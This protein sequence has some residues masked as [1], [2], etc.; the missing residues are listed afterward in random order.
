MHKGECLRRGR[1]RRDGAPFGVIPLSSLL[2]AWTLVASP[3]V[4]QEN[5]RVGPWDSKTEHAHRVGEDEAPPKTG[6]T[7]EDFRLLPSRASLRFRGVVVPARV[8]GVEASRKVVLQSGRLT[9]TKTYA[10]LHDSSTGALIWRAPFQEGATMR[11]V[12]QFGSTGLFWIREADNTPEGD[13]PPGHFDLLHRLN[14]E[15]GTWQEPFRLGHP[16][17]GVQ[18]VLSPGAGLLAVGWPEDGDVPGRSG[19]KGAFRVVCF[20]VDRPQPIWQR[21]FSFV[22]KREEENSRDSAMSES[23]SRHSGFPALSWMGRTLLVCTGPRQPIRAVNGDTGTVLRCVDRVWEFVSDFAGPSVLAYF[24]ARF[25]A[26]DLLNAGLDDPRIQPFR[27]RFEERFRGSMVGGPVAVPLRFRRGDDSHGVFVPYILE[28]R[29]GAVGAHPRSFIV[30]FNDRLEAISVLQLPHVLFGRKPVL[31]DGGVVWYGEDSSFTR[32]APG[33][34]SNEL[35]TGIGY[36]DVSKS[37]LQWVRTAPSP[38]FDAWLVSPVHTRAPAFGHRL[39]IV[40]TAGARILDQD[41]SMFLFPL[42]AVD[43][44]SGRTCE[45]IVDVPFKG[46][47]PAPP[48][49]FASSP[50]RRFETFFPYIAWIKSFSL[51]SGE[52]RCVLHEDDSGREIQL[53]FEFDETDVFAETQDLDEDFIH[54]RSPAA[55]PDTPNVPDEYGRTPL[56]RAAVAHDLR[57]MRFLIEHGADCAARDGKDLTVLMAAADNGTAE[58]VRLLL[59]NGAD[60]RSRERTAPGWSPLAW[61][62]ASRRDSKRK[63]HA[64]LEAG[65]PID[66]RYDGGL[67]ALMIAIQSGNTATVELLIDRGCDL[68]IEDDEGRTALEHAR[69]FD[70]Y[71]TH[72][73][74]DPLAEVVR[75]RKRHRDAAI[76][77][78]R[79]R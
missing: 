68:D 38:H 33:N 78:G 43:L 32:L 39:A 11:F 3:T 45:M 20:D 53:R 35:A 40:Q 47:A 57:R 13:Q 15:D 18:P 7:K 52:L 55:R 64:L 50:W 5:G 6:T 51:E 4:A 58:A 42:V 66:A 65:V 25:G 30:E 77:K 37:G 1:G 46:Q 69:V 22:D 76:A 74:H 17:T 31:A 8:G 71:S 62:A 23:F 54:Q 60:P 26:L 73:G 67:T 9:L 44:I 63:V 34:G 2:L 12:G 10:A 56:H 59:A 36:S 70:A 19:P 27:K 41:D 16:P 14:L 61:A 29:S 21:R 75:R 72:T 79:G 49:N 24:V 28:D 48:M